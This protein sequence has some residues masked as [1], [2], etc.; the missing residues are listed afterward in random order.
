[1]KHN[2]EKP[3]LIDQGTKSNKIALVGNPNVGKSILFNYLTG[4]YVEVSNFPGTT[5]EVYHGSYKNYEVYDT[6]GIYSVASFNDE[7]TVAKDIILDADIVINVVDASHLERDLFLTVQ[8]IEMG[9]KMIV[10]LN[11]FDELGKN[12]ISLNVERLSKSLGIPVV[13]TVAPEGIGFKQLEATIQIA[14]T[15]KTNKHVEKELQ[16]FSE[17]DIPLPEKIL[18]LELDEPTIAKYIGDEFNNTDEIHS[19]IDKTGKPANEIIHGHHRH[20]FD[21]GHG[22]RGHGHHNNHIHHLRHILR[23]SA[24][25]DKI[26]L[27]RRLYVNTL[28]ETVLTNK[29]GKR[30][31]GKIIGKLIINPVT[32]IPISLF[33]LYLVYLFIGVI[34]AGNV[35]TFT[36]GY[37]GNDLYEYNVKKQAAAN[38]SVDVILNIKNE[39]DSL[40]TSQSHFFPNGINKE[41]T[42]FAAL[43]NHRKDGNN[44]LVFKYRNPVMTILFGE[45]GIL[46]MTVTYI[47]FLLLPLVIGFYFMLS[48]LE[49][50]G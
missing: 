26:Y 46:T 2:D 25:R 7:E 36:E 28:M 33:I 40:I 20:G 37:L 29:S 10:A 9:K 32:G 4:I 47:L 5:V 23:H 48:M 8:L 24:G 50:S 16:I 27:L 39:Q 31:I 49:D 21:H 22:H 41:I 34:V 45:F 12:N 13:P 11:M 38:S 19:I 1:M 44:E 18:L 15:G 3:N 35:V 30:N 43:D 42:E 17:A 6:P 14:S